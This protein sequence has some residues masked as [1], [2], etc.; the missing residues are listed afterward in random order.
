MS[1]IQEYLNSAKSGD[2][3]KLKE[4]VESPA[5]IIPSVEVADAE[6]KNA[7]LHA[8]ENNRRAVFKYLLDQQID[9]NCRD[10]NGR[11]ALHYATRDNNK[12][13]VIYLLLLGADWGMPDNNRKTPGLGDPDML[14]FISDVGFFVIFVGY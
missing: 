12:Y 8:A 5:K 2:L 11:T 1:A 6:G 14:S 10:N 3:S 9:I 4:F 7:L 13:F